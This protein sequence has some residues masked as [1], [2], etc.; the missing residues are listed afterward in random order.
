MAEFGKHEWSQQQG[1][2]MSIKVFSSPWNLVIS[3]TFRKQKKYEDLSVPD[4]LV[5]QYCSTIYQK[6]ELLLLTRFD[7]N[8]YL[9]TLDK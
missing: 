1:D 9:C 6:A 3:W 4:R 5:S 7:A 8:R 2:K